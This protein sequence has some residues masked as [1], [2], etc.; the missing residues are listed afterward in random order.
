MTVGVRLPCAPNETGAVSSGLDGGDQRLDRDAWI[1]VDGRLLSGEVN[2][3][4][5]A[6]QLVQLLLDPRRAGSA[7]HPLEIETERLLLG[8]DRRQRLPLLF[9]LGRLVAGLVDRGA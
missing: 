1:A 8:C 9:L 6:V 4:G 7:G 5:D 3:R 2:R